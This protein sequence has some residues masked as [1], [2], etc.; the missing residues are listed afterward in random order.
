MPVTRTSS[1][2]RSAFQL[3][4][5]KRSVAALYLLM[6]VGV[7][8]HWVWS[9][10][11]EYLGDP[12]AGFP[13]QLPLML[14]VRVVLAFIAAA[15]TFVPTYN[16]IVVTDGLTWVPYFLAFQNGFF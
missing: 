14:G 2:L 5:G 9:V 15:L 3:E 4:P 13:T 1:R 11:W 8:A 12:A 6:V 16:K 10:G 7:L